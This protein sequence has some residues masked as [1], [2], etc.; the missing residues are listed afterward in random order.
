MQALRDALSAVSRAADAPPRA[1]ALNHILVTDMTGVAA[2]SSLVK[3]SRMVMLY[4]E[5]IHLPM[6]K[7]VC[8]RHTVPAVLGCSVVPGSTRMPQVSWLAGS[9]LVSCGQVWD[10][11][12]TTRPIVEPMFAA[13]MHGIE[14]C[15]LL[16]GE[17]VRDARRYVLKRPRIELL[18]RDVISQ[19]ELLSEVRPGHNAGFGRLLSDGHEPGRRW[20]IHPAFNVQ[21]RIR[22]CQCC[23]PTTLR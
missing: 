13:A 10:S 5:Y 18:A 9:A 11:P 16:M 2:A 14:L 20:F 4:E 3:K 22:S 12:V 23:G 8:D 6:L 7:Q 1:P 17:F 21:P 19:C 15:F